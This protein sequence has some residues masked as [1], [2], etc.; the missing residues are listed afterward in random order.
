M[1]GGTCVLGCPFLVFS[2]EYLQYCIKIFNKLICTFLDNNDQNRKV[3]LI[4][5]SCTV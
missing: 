4:V 3:T 2:M 5:L 1:K